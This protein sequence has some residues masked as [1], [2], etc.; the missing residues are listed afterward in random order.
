MASQLASLWT[1]KKALGNSEMAYYRKIPK[2]IPGFIFFKGP[3]WGAYL[4][5]E[6][7]VSKSIV[8]AL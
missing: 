2:I 4:Q 3:F 7:C 6:I 1:K 8:L 5:R